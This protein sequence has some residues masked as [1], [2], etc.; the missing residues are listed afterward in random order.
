MKLEELMIDMLI[1]LRMSRTG[2]A[3][4]GLAK[5]QKPI[6]TFKATV[7]HIQVVAAGETVGYGRKYTP[8]EGISYENFQ[9]LDKC[10]CM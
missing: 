7:R 10:R 8:E 2:S 6:M 3:I 4:F 1:V 9:K 5:G